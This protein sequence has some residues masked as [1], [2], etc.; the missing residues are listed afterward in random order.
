MKSQSIERNV[1]CFP[2][3]IKVNFAEEY[4]K[5]VGIIW[6]KSLFM[7]DDKEVA[8]PPWTTL[9]KLKRE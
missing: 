1:K 6:N 3:N 2:Q 9:R 4:H 8:T 7:S 5:H